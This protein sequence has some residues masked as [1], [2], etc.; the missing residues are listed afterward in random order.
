MREMRLLLEVLSAA[1]GDLG[2]L[3]GDERRA[4]SG[5][6]AARKNWLTVPRLIGI[7]YTTPLVHG[8]HAVHVVGEGA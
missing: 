3:L 2:G 4:C 6:Q 7:G 8:V 1:P 5:R